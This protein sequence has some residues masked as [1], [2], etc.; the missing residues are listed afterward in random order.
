M[1]ARADVCAPDSIASHSAGARDEIPAPHSTPSV[2]ARA[3]ASA[4]ASAPCA[5]ASRS[6]SANRCR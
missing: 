1:E 6:A 5:K 4:M 2:A 3:S